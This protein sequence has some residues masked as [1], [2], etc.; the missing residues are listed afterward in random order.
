MSVIGIKASDSD[1]EIYPESETEES[2]NSKSQQPDPK[3][4]KLKSDIQ[5]LAR[6]VESIEYKYKY[7]CEREKQVIQS[8]KNEMCPTI[9]QQCLENIYHK[10]QALKIEIKEMKKNLDKCGKRQQELNQ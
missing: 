1:I 5:K 7:L 9:V 10:K 8:S 4:L 3:H 6:S 2:L